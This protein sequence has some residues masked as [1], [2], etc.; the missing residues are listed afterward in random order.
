MKKNLKSVISFV[1]ALGLCASSAGALAATTYTDVPADA[2]YA[3]AVANLTAIGIVEGDGNGTFRP[4]DKITRAEVAAMVVRAMAQNDAAISSKG[5]TNFTDVSA[6]NWASGYI[7]VASRGTGAFINGMGDGTFEPD[8]NVTYAQIVKMVVAAI[9]YGDWGVAAG[10]YPTGYIATAKQLNITDGVS[11]VNADDEVSRAVVAQL[12]NNAIDTPLLSLKTYSP[13]NPEYVIMNGKDDNDYE[14]VLTY[15]HDIYK[16]EGRVKDT[17]R[18]NSSIDADEIRYQI[19]ATNNYDDSSISMLKKN[20]GITYGPYLMKVGDTDV[21]DY[22]DVYSKLLVKVTD[23]ED[24]VVLSCVASGKNVTTTLQADAWDDEYYSTEDESLNRVFGMDK[25][26]TSL[27]ENKGQLWYYSNSDKTGKSTRYYLS[28][29]FRLYVNGVE[30]DATQANVKDYIFDNETGTV[31]LVDTVSETENSTDGKY[32]S[33]YVSYFATGIVESVNSNGKVYFDKVANTG[34]NTTTYV[35]FDDDDDDLKYS[36]SLDGKDVKYSDLQKGDVISVSY[37]VVDGFGES[38]FY[39]V[40]VSRNTAEGKVTETNDEDDEIGI[41]GTT[42]KMIADDLAKVGDFNLGTSYT[43]Y[44]DAFGKVADFEKLA[45][46][47]KYG[48]INRFYYS[49]DAAE[50]KFS[51]YDTTATSKT[52]DVADTM[53]ITIDGTETS[54]ETSKENADLNSVI[55]SLDDKADDTNV[56]ERVVE[57]TTNSSGEIKTIEFLNKSKSTSSYTAKSNKLGSLKFDDATVMI[58]VDGT[59]FSVLKTSSLIDDN[60][61]TAYGYDRDNSVYGFIVVTDGVSSFTKDTRFA[62]VNKV[63]QGS[64]EDGDDCDKIQL[65]TAGSKD[66]QTVYTD[67]TDVVYGKLK[68]GDVIIYK[69]NASGLIEDAEDVEVVF[70]ASLN[71]MTNFT[72]STFI[73]TLNNEFYSSFMDKFDMPSAWED[74]ENEVELKFGPIIDRSSSSITLGKLSNVR[75]EK[76]ES[77]TGEEDKYTEYKGTFTYTEDDSVAG[78][79]VED[80]DYASDVAVYVYDFNNSSDNRL[81]VG[82]VS[83]VPKTTV[84]EKLKVNDSTKDATIID[85]S[86]DETPDFAYALVKMVEDDVTDVFV[87]IPKD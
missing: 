4:D 35:E 30:V 25:D 54:Y 19:E 38:N 16:V 56:Q 81:S 87:I 73:D 53:K 22:L 31:T 85:W 37:N 20:D 68:K 57:Y 1:I 77:A 83:S 61:Y 36:I 43:I 82:T 60:D 42:Y 45:S 3:E 58:S 11:G 2:S 64:N 44:L 6:D 14:T 80:L 46:S 79:K 55:S 67:G 47:V 72:N 5:T 71:G 41:N 51:M 28:D 75:Y 49:T 32:D 21:A 40:L 69:T 86:N 59:D 17:H 29:G 65:Y 66:L 10:G 13:T 12:I 52:Y 78:V 62:V 23:D 24:P 9:G 74:E 8:S 15:Y 18:S 84:S 48:I 76:N 39:D 70:S 34:S 63:S 7:N 33:I 27:G 26:G 50:Y